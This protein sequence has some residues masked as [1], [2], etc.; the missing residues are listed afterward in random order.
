MLSGS[1]VD[2]PF[3]RSTRNK[4]L[5]HAIDLSSLCRCVRAGVSLFR[6]YSH[7]IKTSPI[8][9]HI[10][11]GLGRARRGTRRIALAEIALYD[12]ACGRVVVNRPERTRDS[13]DLAANTKGI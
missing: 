3:E 2:V 12:L 13:T 10:S 5:A 8:R 7:F 4:F 1:L 6:P 9:V 11:D